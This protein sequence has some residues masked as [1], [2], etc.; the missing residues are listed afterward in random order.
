M[1]IL[2]TMWNN[3]AVTAN[4]VAAAKRICINKN[5]LNVDD[6]QHNKYEQAALLIDKTDDVSLEPSTPKKTRSVT[7]KDGPL[8]TTS[9]SQSKVAK[10]KGRYG[11]AE[12][13]KSMYEMSQS[14]IEESFEKSL[15]LA[16]VPGLLSVNRVKSKEVN[17]T[18][19]IR[20][21]NVYGS[22]EAQD[23]LSKVAFLEGEKQE[24]T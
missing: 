14:F 3:W 9:R 20:V 17:Q 19:I 5:G 23:V 8:A 2:G 12:Y 11:S 22:L 4:I 18:K 7:S 1:N 24:K 10:T 6:L 15:N 16:E 13:W 21:T